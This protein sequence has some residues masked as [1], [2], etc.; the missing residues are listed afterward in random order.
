MKPRYEQISLLEESISANKLK[1]EEKIWPGFGISAG[2]DPGG[3]QGH[4]RTPPCTACQSQLYG[5]HAGWLQ[6]STAPVT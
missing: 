3:V 4:D 1:G 5:K 6:L 2:E